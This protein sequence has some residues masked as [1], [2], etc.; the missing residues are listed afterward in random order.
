[1]SVFICHRK[2]AIFMLDFIMLENISL[3]FYAPTVAVVLVRAS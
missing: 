1:M 2:T 3:L